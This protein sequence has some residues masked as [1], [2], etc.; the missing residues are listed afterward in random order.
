MD[1][2][3]AKVEMINRGE[4]TIIE[5]GIAELIRGVVDENRLRATEDVA[6]AVLRSRLSLICVGTPSRPNGSIDLSYIERVCEQIG[7]TVAGEG[8]TALG[9]DP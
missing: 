9:R 4:S 5:E 3:L 6:E 8:R 1:V 2:Q 7:E